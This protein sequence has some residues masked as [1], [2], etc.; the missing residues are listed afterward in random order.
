M[1]RKLSQNEYSEYS[2]LNVLFREISVMPHREFYPLVVQLAMRHRR[3]LYGAQLRE[4]WRPLAI[5][6][7]D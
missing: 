1:P 2:A 7:G 3:S 5:C 4:A 6:I